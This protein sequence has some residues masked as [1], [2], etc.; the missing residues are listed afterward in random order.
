MSALVPLEKDTRSYRKHV[1][2]DTI[3][4]HLKMRSPI[5][6]RTHIGAVPPNRFKESVRTA[7]MPKAARFSAP[8]DCSLCR[9]AHQGL[10]SVNVIML[11]S[12]WPLMVEAAC[13]SRL[14]SGVLR[15]PFKSVK[16]QIAEAAQANIVCVV[17]PPLCPART[18]DLT[19]QRAP[20]SIY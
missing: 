20:S 15:P 7:H 10:A 18:R 2:R 3:A 16:S 4:T 17:I 14:K 13:S 1:F 6:R 12:H 8:E 19:N 11:I 5:A 9:F